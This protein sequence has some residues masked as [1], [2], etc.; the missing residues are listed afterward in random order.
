MEHLYAV[1]IGNALALP[2]KTILS[3]KDLQGTNTLAYYKNLQITPVKSF[4][5]LSLGL[6][7]ALY[8]ILFW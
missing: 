7:L 8:F 3:L 4:L 6:T 2:A 1:S 5:T